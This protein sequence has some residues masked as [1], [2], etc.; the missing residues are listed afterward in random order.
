MDRLCLV[1]VSK[2]SCFVV[3]QLENGCLLGATNTAYI[4]TC[5]MPNRN[6]DGL[7]SLQE[8]QKPGFLLWSREQQNR[9]VPSSDLLLHLDPFYWCLCWFQCCWWR[10]DVDQTSFLFEQQLYV[11]QPDEIKLNSEV[12]LNSM[13]KQMQE[14]F[15]N[16]DKCFNLPPDPSV[17]CV[18]RSLSVQK[19]WGPLLN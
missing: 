8:H 10:G 15:K 13:L 18:K 17:Y 11:I 1:P 5:L 6:T 7:S 14:I 12:Q 4:R 16:I 2:C 3:S 19:V 9:V